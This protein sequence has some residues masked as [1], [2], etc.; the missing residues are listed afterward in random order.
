[1]AQGQISLARDGLERLFNVSITSG[2]TERADKSYIV[3][4]DDISIW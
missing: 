2:P 3:T 1:L 4:L